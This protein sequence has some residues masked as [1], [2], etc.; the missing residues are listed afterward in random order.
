MKKY[1]YII[2]LFLVSTFGSCTKFVDYNPQEDYQIT[3][4]NYFKTAEDYHK[5]AIG[6]YSPMQWLWS[7]PVIGEVASDNS[8]S[9]G[10]NATDNIAL[11]QIDDYQI[12]ANNSNLTEIW[13]ACYE[14]INRANYLEENKAKLDFT[15][16]N[17]LYGE[18]Y[19]LR[20][21]Y[22]FELVKMFGGVP[23][24]TNKRLSVG[25]SNKFQRATKAQVYAQIEIDL[26][27]AIAAL[28]VSNSQQGRATKHAAQALLG[29][30]YLY[31]DKFTD[32]AA[33]L[34]NVVTGPF[35][36]A[37]NYGTIFL[38]A[39]ENG[40]E[41]VFEV[42]YSNLSPFYDWSNPGRGQGNLAVQICGIRNLTGTSPYASGWSTNLPTANLAAAFDAG[43]T[44]K[45]V[46]VLDIEAYKTAN[47]GMNITYTVA[48]YK[49]T[50][51]YNQKYLPRVGQTSG[52]VELNYLNNY[53]AIRYADVLLMA[54]EAN[55]R[56]AAPNDVK[57]L[58]YL[59]RVRDRAFG[60]ILHR[61]TATGT[62][63]KTAIWDERRLELGM[64]GHRFFDL[65]RTGQAASKITGWVANKN[66]VF[67]I[68]QAEVDISGLTQNPGYN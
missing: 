42:Q 13:K 35:S 33:M 41:S 48:P 15:G 57:A 37:T 51:L 40:S 56:M 47:A 3:A 63:L 65:V 19:F 4:D 20:A 6:V 10:E 55:N 31:Q 36:L 7:I 43:D 18:V 14:G 30:V 64:E 24:F 25:D 60:D 44:R 53:R 2:G 5:M 16:K 9:G 22:Y 66:E 21:Y 58:L 39:G 8:V 45:A 29:K 23:L 49:N 59:N 52:Q 46:T 68:P 67:P 28:P 32:A 34:E 12:V 61:S 1:T 11:Q 26:T 17:A 38:Q 54:A 62:A 27:A 50:G